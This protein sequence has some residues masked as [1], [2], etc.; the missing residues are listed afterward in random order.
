MDGNK[1]A[2]A[3]F[4]EDEPPV[5]YTLTTFVSPAGSGSVTGEGTYDPG[6]TA[7]VSAAAF[8]GWH[9]TGWSGDLTGDTNPDGILMNSNKTVIAN[10]AED[11]P[12]TYT[13]TM[14]VSPTG[15]GT[16]IPVVGG[17]Y[18]YSAGTVV[19][20]SATAEA[21]FEFNGWTAPAGTFGNASAA[22][23]TFTMPAQ[24]VT[25]T[26]TF[27]ENTGCLLVKVY[28][29]EGAGFGAGTVTL[30]N[31]SMTFGPYDTLANGWYT[32]TNIPVGTYTLEADRPGD[33][34][35]VRPSKTVTITI[36]TVCQGEELHYTK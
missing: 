6:V 35:W 36:G 20:I 16:T 11:E 21:G 31:S 10:F 25:V 4:V 27:D 26:A 7:N 29:P 24:N 32:F 12:V 3:N 9:F 19:I 2:I 1:T 14:Q 23:T 8:T 28:N 22:V 30:S 13:L 17:P 18:T 15:S 33:P 5:T 34:G